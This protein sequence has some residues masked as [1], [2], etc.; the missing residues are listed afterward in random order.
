MVYIP[1][2][3]F[4]DISPRRLDGCEDTKEEWSSIPL[5]LPGPKLPSRHNALLHYS[6]ST[7][8]VTQRHTPNVAVLTPNLRGEQKVEQAVLC[9]GKKRNA[10]PS[11]HNF[12]RLLPHR[13]LSNCCTTVRNFACDKEEVEPSPCDMHTCS[14]SS[15]L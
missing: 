1:G 5:C 10:E 8:G 4:C 2:N 13:R 7:R 3:G 14:C 15:N 11:Q 12:T 9:L 6:G